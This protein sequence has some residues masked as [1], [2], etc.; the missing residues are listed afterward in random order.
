MDPRLPPAARARAPAA[1]AARGGRRPVRAHAIPEFGDLP[2]PAAA[3]GDPGRDA[4]RKFDLLPDVLVQQAFH[5]VVCA[6]V[7]VREH[8]PR[9]DRCAGSCVKYRVLPGWCRCRSCCE[10]HVSVWSEYCCLDWVLTTLGSARP[11]IQPK[12]EA[13]RALYEGK[14]IIVGRDKLDVVK[15]VVQ[16]VGGP[17]SFFWLLD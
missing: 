1:D 6:C 2:L 4:R 13:L 7:R 11:G 10:G 5:V 16:K 12:L 15:G 9:R 14:K 17:S 8:G 3:E